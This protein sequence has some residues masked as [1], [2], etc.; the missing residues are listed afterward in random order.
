MQS[1]VKNSM[2]RT[3]YTAHNYD[4]YIITITICGRGGK[5]VAIQPINSQILSKV[6]VVSYSV[7]MVM[8]LRS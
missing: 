5:L 6:S 7:V 2:R 3:L 4:N 1:K 8:S